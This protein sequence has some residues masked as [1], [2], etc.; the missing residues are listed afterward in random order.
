MANEYATLA[1]FTARYRKASANPGDD[2]VISS[3]IEKASRHI[4]QATGRWFYASTQTRYFNTPMCRELRL[5]APL[6][7][8]TTLTNGDGTTIAGTEYYFKPRNAKP[9]YE[10]VLKPTSTTAWQTAADGLNEYVI[11][12]AGSWGWVDRTA[13]DPVSAYYIGATNEAALELAWHWYNQRSGENVS[14]QV[15]I[16]AAGVIVTQSGAVPRNVENTIS[17]LRNKF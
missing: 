7:A 3:L 9:Y 11:A 12:V 16:T 14:G 1:E 17:A 13:S 15:N 4:D 10:I 8:V 2:T 5:D 6:L